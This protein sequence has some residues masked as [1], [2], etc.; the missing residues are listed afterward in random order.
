MESFPPQTNGSVAEQVNRLFD[1]LPDV[2]LFVKD[3]QGRFTRANTAWLDMHGC[4][5]EAEAIGKSD[6]DFHPPA[7]ASQYVAEDARVMESREPLANQAWL[8][9]DYRGTPQWYLCTKLPL[10][11]ADGSVAGIAGIL[12]PFDQAGQAPD[13]YR[14][15][16]PVIEEVTRN[17]SRR[18]A[19]GDLARLADLSP[20]QLQ[21]EFRR[22]FGMTVA[23]YVARIRLVMA[24]RRL[25]ESDAAIGQVAREC[26]FHDQAHFTKAF[27]KYAGQTPR[28]YRERWRS[29][30]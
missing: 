25:R 20:S 21:R 16:T 13:E 15:L 30:Q 2:F 23:D 9:A 11:A 10:I 1:A 18:L 8:V 22:L 17:F 3:C 12:R 26:G 28:Q 29:H 24:S 5:S 27:K 14:R 6:F 4:R 7:L 19:V